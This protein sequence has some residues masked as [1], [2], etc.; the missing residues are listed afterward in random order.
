MRLVRLGRQPA[1]IADDIRAALAALGR[2]STVGG[3]IALI[4][5]QP[6]GCAEP[7]DAI[8]VLPKG[9][10]IVIG[11]DLPDPAM[12]LEAPLRGQW[13]ADGWPLVRTDEAT[14]P[15]TEAL[16]LSE[17]I[18]TRLAAELPSCPPVGTVVAV[19][20]FV[21]TVEQPPADLAGAVRVLHP[22]PTSMLA[23]TVSLA[24]AKR[25]C[26]APTARALLDLLAPGTPSLDDDVL[27]AEGFYAAAKNERPALAEATV[28][29]PVTPVPRQTHGGWASPQPSTPDPEPVVGEEPAPTERVEPPAEPEA[30]AE[31]VAEAPAERPPEPL[32][33]PDEAEGLEPVVWPSEADSRGAEPVAPEPVAAVSPAPAAAP[34]AETPAA[35]AP[36]PRKPAVRWLPIAAIGLLAVLVITAIVSATSGGDDPAPV[37]ASSAPPVT[38]A[39][40]PPSSSS[41]APTSTPSAEVALTSRASSADARCASHGFGDVQASLGRTSCSEVRRGSFDATVDGRKAAVSVAVVSFPDA[42][43][44]EEFRKTADNPGGGGI[45]DVATEQ[46]KWDGTAPRFEGAA[47]ASALDGKSVRLVQ[48]V[49]AAGTSSTEDPGLVR[50]AKAALTTSLGP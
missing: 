6:A 10:L 21:E 18:G 13:K 9:V 49:W 8:L 47:Y 32:P 42:R 23:A 12:R 7:V 37:A 30:P 39:P 17:A 38:P 36:S 33:E 3:G 35:K 11:V 20:P 43:T 15:A 27:F 19:G 48:A 26:S 2:G 5:P 24:S 41:P 25:P 46:S 34:T 28:T 31:P 16:A 4:G 22:T 40:P 44:A 45:I 1:R 50:A 14:N 29:V